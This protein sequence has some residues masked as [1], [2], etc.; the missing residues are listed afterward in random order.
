MTD[1]D[2][3]SEAGVVQ[4]ADALAG[5]APRIWL[6]QQEILKRVALGGDRASIL[7]DIVKV[8]ED[9]T[10]DEMLASILLLSDD[11]EYL[12]LG[13][14]PT[15]PEDY[16][17]AI[18]GMRIGLGE[19]SCGTAASS[20]EPVYVEDI[21]TDPLWTDFRDL[22]AAHGLASCWSVPIKAGNGKVLGT[23]ANY[24]RTPRQ[25]SSQDREIIEAVA[26][27]TAI[28]IEHIRLE[29]AR[30]R[31]ELA[32]RVVLEELQ[33]R[34]KN[35]YTLAQSLINLNVKN[36]SSAQELA[37]KVT[38]K[39]RAIAA[40]QDL[41]VVRDPSGPAAADLDLAALLERILE[42]LVFDDG[43]DRIAMTGDKVPVNPDWLS[44]MAM[45]F[46]ELAT[47]STKYGALGQAEGRVAIRWE[48]GASEL[49]ITWDEAGGPETTAPE[50]TSF[51]SRL[52]AACLKQ[53]GGTIDYDWRP[54]G[55]LAHMTLPHDR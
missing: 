40:S 54:E 17:Q 4:G 29:E 25:P 39:L 7:S 16:N 27:T 20:G 5:A 26:L 49:A 21:S 32:K 33:H 42:P 45:V 22:A 36:A 38:D 43:E 46:H 9:Q 52:V 3:A 47:N 18:H 41:I 10:E 6:R 30:D 2:A 11:G 55:L 53:L 28:A 23:F 13:G 37:T 31:A 24:Y 48:V 8:A 50:T 12:L 1:D 14:A 15:L 19:G 44:S 35:A 34:V 51:G